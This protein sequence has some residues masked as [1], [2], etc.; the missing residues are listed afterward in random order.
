[1][2]ACCWDLPRNDLGGLVFGSVVGVG[3]TGGF[4]LFATWLLRNV[5]LQFTWYAPRPVRAE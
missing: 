1:M 4:G 5:V 2:G 3:G